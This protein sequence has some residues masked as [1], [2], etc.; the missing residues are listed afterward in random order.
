MSFFYIKIQ[1][2]NIIKKKKGVLS[3]GAS[4]T[5]FWKIWVIFHMK[6]VK[7]QKEELNYGFCFVNINSSNTQQMELS[8]PLQEFRRKVNGS[9]F[10]C[11]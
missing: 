2:L 6:D 1:H 5:L 9:L 7:N 4:K 3:H 8:S 11:W 10:V